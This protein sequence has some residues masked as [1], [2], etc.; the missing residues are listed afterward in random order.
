MLDGLLSEEQLLGL[1]IVDDHW[2]GLSN[3]QASVFSCLR[4]EASGFVYWGENWQAIPLTNFEVFLTMT[5][6]HVN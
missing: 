2:V 6:C 3:S 5:R 1:K 4:S